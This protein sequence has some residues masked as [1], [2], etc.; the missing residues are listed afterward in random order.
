[1]I[2][3]RPPTDPRVA[4]T[5]PLSTK[6]SKTAECPFQSSLMKTKQA[7]LEEVVGRVLDPESTNRLKSG[8]TRRA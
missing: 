3:R 6:K 8:K 4:N 1:M 7:G 5:N 2:R